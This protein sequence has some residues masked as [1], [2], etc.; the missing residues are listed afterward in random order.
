MKLKRKNMHRIKGIKIKKS[1]IGLFALILIIFGTILLSYNYLILKKNKIYEQMNLL[2]YEGAEPDNIKQDEP[3]VEE[4]R[5]K[6]ATEEAK[7]NYQYIGVLEIPKINLKRGFVDI[8]SKYNNVS[9][10]IT[11][12]ETSRYPDQ[13]RGNFILAAHSGNCYVCFFDKLWKLTKGDYAYIHY[14]NIKYNYKIV[15]IYD[16]EKTGEVEIKRD[17]YKTTLTLITCTHNSD[18]KQ[19]V[20]ILELENTEQ[21]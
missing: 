10:N 19:T 21:E 16:V 8:N 3:V 4:E 7:F 11:I 9:R 17:V 15:D 18:T 5:T 14:N 1:S 20:Y 12:I 6:S 2:L 13:E